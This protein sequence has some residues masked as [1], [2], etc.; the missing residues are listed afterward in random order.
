MKVHGSPQE[1]PLSRAREQQRRRAKALSY[2]VIV[3]ALVSVGPTCLPGLLALPD[4]GPKSCRRRRRRLAPSI[5]CAAAIGAA[6]GQKEGL[7]G[8]AG[9][10]FLLPQRGVAVV[11]PRHLCGGEV[12]DRSTSL[13]GSDSA[14]TSAWAP[15]P[16]ALSKT[17][18]AS[19]Q[20][21]STA[22]SELEPHPPRRG[23]FIQIWDFQIS[24]NHKKAKFNGR[25]KH[26]KFNW[27]GNFALS[28][29]RPCNFVL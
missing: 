16:P 1:S 18:T 12:H 24:Q 22:S 5:R 27:W 10:A 6:A 26:V 25:Y 14:A 21:L 28:T 13:S 17:V 2:R 9:R 19:P 4:R 11:P 7:G 20:V 3:Q 15:Q 29:E 8:A 23:N